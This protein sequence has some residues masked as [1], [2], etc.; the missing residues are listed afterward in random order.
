MKEM[1]SR[2]VNL[3]GEE[4]FNKL[5]NSNI[6]LFGVGGVGG[7]I[8]ESLVRAGIENITIVDADVVEESNLNR[9]IIA[10]KDSLKKDKVLV[11]KERALTINEDAKIKTLK[12]FITPENLENI[13]FKPFDFIIDAIDFTPAKIAIIKKAKEEN[14]NIISS[15]GTGNKLHPDKF[16]IADISKTEVCPLAKVIRQNLKKDGI[17][18]VPVLFSKEVPLTPKASENGKHVPATLSTVPAV[19]GL[20]IANYVILKITEEN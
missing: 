12:T 18:N 9:Q 6:L 10:T 20:L 11:A 2:T 14:I 16:E 8:F 1:F 5:K 3:L 15:M 13:D 19:A 4:K 17:K 7:Y